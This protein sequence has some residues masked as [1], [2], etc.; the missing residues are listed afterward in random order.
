MKNRFSDEAIWRWLAIRVDLFQFGDTRSH[1]PTHTFKH[2]HTRAH[3]R[4][5]LSLFFWVPSIFL[6]GIFGVRREII[7]QQND[8]NQSKDCGMSS[9]YTLAGVCRVRICA[10][11]VARFADISWLLLSVQ[12]ICFCLLFVVGLG[13]GN[14]GQHVTRLNNCC[15]PWLCRFNPLLTDDRVFKQSAPR[16]PIEVTA[17]H[18]SSYRKPNWQL[19]VFLWKGKHILLRGKGGE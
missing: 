1:T 14:T 12:K 2:T 17:N 5:P 15:A 8:F 9:S 7:Y 3:S 10:E 18:R 11:S 6:G 13:E 4:R 19:N 16:I